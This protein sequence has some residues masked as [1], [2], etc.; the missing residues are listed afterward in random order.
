VPLSAGKYHG[1]PPALLYET[2]PPRRPDVS[3]SQRH[4]RACTCEEASEKT[5]AKPTH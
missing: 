1:L 4:P 2:T 3:P 5:F